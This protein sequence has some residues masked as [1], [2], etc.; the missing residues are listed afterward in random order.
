MSAGDVIVGFDGTDVDSP[1]TL[2]NLVGRHRPGD[3]VA[4]VWTDR[5][6]QQRTATVTLVEG[7]PA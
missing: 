1:N 3:R 4:L 5:G 6:G 2:T 7:P